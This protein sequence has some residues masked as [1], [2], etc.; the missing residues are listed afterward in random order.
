[1]KK[2]KRSRLDIATPILP[3]MRMILV[4]HGLKTGNIKPLV[5]EIKKGRLHYVA[6]HLNEESIERLVRA[7]ETGSPLTSI[8]RRSTRKQRLQRDRTLLNRIVYWRARGKHL[9]SHDSPDGAVNHACQD[10]EKSPLSGAPTRTPE[11]AYKHV[12]LSFINEPGKPLESEDDLL[13]SLIEGLVDANVPSRND[14][15]FQWFAENIMKKRSILIVRADVKAA[16][17]E[18][19]NQ[20]LSPESA[21]GLSKISAINKRRTY[22]NRA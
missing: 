14:E 20:P 6:H 13:N 15:T 22:I 3:D 9:F 10:Y 18:L 17:S 16:L 8:E 11:S 1:M 12:Y 19:L 4:T 7:L 21:A 2:K 5:S